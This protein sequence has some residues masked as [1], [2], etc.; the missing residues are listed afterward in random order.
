MYD[1]MKKREMNLKNSDELGFF[2]GGGITFMM[3]LLCSD[4]L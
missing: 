4:F 1:Q 3:F 2:F